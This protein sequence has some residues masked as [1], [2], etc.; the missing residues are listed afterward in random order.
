MK[1]VMY[2]F[3]P[4]I[5]VPIIF[6]IVTLLEDTALLESIVPYVLFAALFIFAFAIGVLSPSKTR[7]D[8]IM[9]VI[10]PISVLVCLFIFL[11]F[12]EGCD[13]KLQ[14]SLH[15]TLNMEYYK[16]WLPIALI[17]MVITFIASF[18][19]IRNVVKNIFVRKK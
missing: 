11:F 12:D 16:V 19:P 17:M 1:K 14:F 2:Y 6:L 9:T 7:F 5:V 13:G 3:S 4:F 10:V 8:Y 15:H 18:T